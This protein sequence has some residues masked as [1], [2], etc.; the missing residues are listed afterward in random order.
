MCQRVTLN[1]FYWLKVKKGKY[2]LK[3]LCKRFQVQTQK[4]KILL[5]YLTVNVE[6]VF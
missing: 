3:V 4:R 1:S 2:R 6:R 5:T